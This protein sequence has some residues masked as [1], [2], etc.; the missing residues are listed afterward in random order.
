MP[1]NYQTNDRI[2]HRWV[3]DHFEEEIL[4]LSGANGITINVG[5][6][7]FTISGN[8][9]AVQAAL[10]DRV[11]VAGD[12]MTGALLF[13]SGVSITQD[14][15][16][17][18]KAYV[19]AASASAGFPVQEDGSDV[20]DPARTLNFTHALNV[21]SGSELASISVDEA[22]FD[23]AVVVMVS[24]SQNIMGS[25]TFMS[26][27]TIMADLNV[28]G[29]INYLDTETLLIEDNSIVLNATFS[30][31][32]TL[33]A[34]IKVE[35]GDEADAQIVWNEL[36][37]RWEFGVSGA[38]QIF[39]SSGAL[40]A[41][42]GALHDEIVT[43]SDTVTSGYIA[44]DAALSGVLQGMWQSDDSTLSG[45]LQ[46][47][48][49]GKVAKAGDTM[50]GDLTLSGADLLTAASGANSVGAADVP[51]GYGYF[52]NLFVYSAPDTDY[53]VV[54]KAY[55][56]SMVA[57]AVIEVQE[58]GG[59]VSSGASFFDFRTGLDVATSG[60]GVVISIDSSEITGVVHTTGNE[61]IS[62]TKTFF[63]PVVLAAGTE[64]LVSGTGASGELRWSDD[65]L[66]V[67]VATDTWKRIALATY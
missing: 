63:S 49:D 28:S 42:S 37:D 55:V 39:T 13:A 66:Y 27:V 50:S 8:D 29:V 20:V 46:G 5:S 33:D 22:A 32:P 44:A 12:T 54:N 6:G 67:C 53:D 10:D 31:A 1:I 51:F 62:G 16:A 35:R 45:A 14:L 11:L 3:T 59:V 18:T 43:V 57:G 17:A 2:A 65:Y 61:A 4:T 64:P 7:A 52:D 34:S 26:D 47:A 56:D 30:G 38:M 19:D 21:T 24:G 40:V 41:M 58:D 23:T 60:T 25:K 48:I 36:Y 15:Q 9:A